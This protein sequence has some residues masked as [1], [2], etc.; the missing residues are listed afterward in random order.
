MAGTIGRQRLALIEHKR[1]FDVTVETETVGLEI[2]AVRA[3]REQ[4]HGDV[5]RAMAGDGKIERFRQ[6]RDLDERDTPPQLVTS[7]SG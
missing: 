4:V 2:E 1:M 6:P 5:V 7:G 3:G